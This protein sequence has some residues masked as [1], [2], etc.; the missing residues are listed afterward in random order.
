M[1]CE[2]HNNEVNECEEGKGGEKCGEVRQKS[3]EPCVKGV[4]GEHVHV[5]V[6]HELWGKIMVITYESQVT[7]CR[8]TSLMYKSC[9]F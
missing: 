4:G 5:V 9:Q 8:L 7:G 1:A 3:S 6:R 2:R